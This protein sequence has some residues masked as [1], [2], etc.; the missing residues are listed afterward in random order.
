MPLLCQLK[1]GPEGVR[2]EGSIG[3]P[4]CWS[5]VFGGHVPEGRKMVARH[6][7]PAFP[8]LPALTP[9]M[10]GAFGGWSRRGGGTGWRGGGFGL[11]GRCV[12]L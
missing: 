9:M 7:M 4:E 8:A 12:L 3:V 2:S 11:W 5:V 6:E 1:F 10:N